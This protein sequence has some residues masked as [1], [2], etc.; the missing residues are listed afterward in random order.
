VDELVRPI[1]A[2]AAKLMHQSDKNEVKA[3]FS[4]H[5]SNLIN[6]YHRLPHE[7]GGYEQ[8][9]KIRDLLREGRSVLA[10]QSE[11]NFP[12][13]VI[14]TLWDMSEALDTRRI[15]A[16]KSASNEGPDLSA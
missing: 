11:L 7:P 14:S 2:A 16:Q 4:E 3:F 1:R 5:E 8:Q 12:G 9:D 15:E 6:I 10:D 13:H